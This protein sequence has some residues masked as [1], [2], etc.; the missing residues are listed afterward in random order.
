M[1]SRFSTFAAAVFA[2]VMV[3]DPFFAD[4]TDAA[5]ARQQAIEARQDA[6]RNRCI[7]YGFEEGTDSFAQCLMTI[8][9]QRRAIAAQMLSH[10]PQPPM[11]SPLSLIAPAT[12]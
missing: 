10:A 2:F 3:P 6:D 11:P 7:N 4:E 9:Q 5:A 12:P 8:D 1:T